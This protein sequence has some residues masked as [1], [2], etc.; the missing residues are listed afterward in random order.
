MAGI[1]AGAQA[2]TVAINAKQPQANN[3]LRLL[4]TIDVTLPIEN[5]AQTLW[6]LY[7]DQAV[8][9]ALQEFCNE[10]YWKR[11]WIIQEFAIGHR[12][13][14][15][16]GHKLV[17]VQALDSLLQ[18]LDKEQASQAF[19]QVKAIFRIRKAWQ[20]AQPVRLLDILRQTASSC[21]GRQHDRV[22]G[23]LGLVVDFLDFL[24]EPNY[25][26]T[27]TT[28]SM[29][30]TQSY[31]ARRSLNIILLAQH[32][33]SSHNLPSWCPDY[34]GFHDFPPED[35]IFAL[36]LHHQDSQSADETIPAWTATGSSRAVCTFHDNILVSTAYRIGTIC[37][38]GSA[39]SDAADAPFP[40][41]NES[42]AST[43]KKSKVGK[44]LSMATLSGRYKYNQSYESS[45]PSSLSILE[46]YCFVHAF[47][48]EHAKSDPEDPDKLQQWICAN[49]Q[50]FTGGAT[51]QDH[52]K[53]L[54]PIFFHCGCAI[55]SQRKSSEPTVFHPL[56]R[57][58]QEDMRMICL[59]DPK[60]GIGWA[61]NGARLHDEVFLLPGCSVPVILRRMEQDRQYRLIGDAIVIG[62]M[63]N[64]IWS[65]L[66]PAET[67]QI[68]IV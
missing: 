61:T 65:T 29:S 22:F 35:R 3:L 41:H 16:L 67:W 6:Q 27:L 66:T 39:W 24:S 25:N 47:L 36:T 28:V 59:D 48:S 23:I 20:T 43:C 62:A 14:L 57:M 11:I 44:P 38:I 32:H 45:R 2:V 40:S 19:D 64:E 12:I 55:W 58:A 52:A 5:Q 18:L 68:Q 54:W 46:A 1:Y 9:A 7:D 33:G 8:R 56:I 37:S 53:R 63:K 26:T 13:N 30:M 17:D 15:L 21:C 34:F 50:F 42:W 31:I 51:L 49:R 4:S 10:S 60:F